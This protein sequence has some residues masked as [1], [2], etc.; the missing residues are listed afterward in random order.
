MI[1]LGYLELFLAILRRNLW[2]LFFLTLLGG[3]ALLC[4]LLFFRWQ[5]LIADEKLYQKARVELVAQSVDSVLRTQE[6]VLDV[7]GRELLNKDNMLSGSRQIPFLDSILAANPLLV[8]FG[9]ARPDGTLVRVSTNLDLSTLP[10]L[11]DDPET[12]ESFLQALSSKVM[13]VG[14]TYFVDAMGAWVIPIRKAIRSETGEV[15]AVMTAGMRLD[16]AGSVLSKTLHDSAADRVLLFR[17]ADGFVQF[18]SAEGVGPQQY[19]KIRVPVDE[20]EKNRTAFE[21]DLGLSVEEVMRRNDSVVVRTLR[22]GG[23]YLTAA[24]FNERYQLWTI[25]ETSFV[26]LHREF[27]ESLMQYL[28]VFLVVGVVFYRGFRI[29]DSA[30]KKRRQELSYLSKHDDL[31][32][33]LNRSGLLDCIADLL[34]DKKP[35]CLVVVN[36]DNFKGINDRFGLETGDEA[37]LEFSRRLAELVESR[38][39]LARLSGDEF[40]IVTSNS[41]LREVE[42][43]CLS[44]ANDLARAFEVGRLTLQVT[45]S[46]GVASFPEHGDSLSKVIRSAHLALYEAK[47]SR[48]DVC[49]YRTEMEMA[50][51]R[52]LSVEQR[53]RYGLASGA[54]YMAYQPQVDETKKTVGLEAL[55]R[56]SDEELGFVSPAEFVEVA[57]KSGLMLPLGRFVVETSIREYSLLRGSIGRSMDLAINISVIQFRQPDFVETVLG[58]LHVH[59]V[60]P[61]ELVLEITETL[62][63]SDFEKVLRTIERLREHGIRIS[64]DD[65]GTGY[66]S[67]S[68]LRKLPIDELKIDKSFVDTILEDEKAANMVRSIIAIARSHNMELV[69]EGVEEEAQARVLIEMGCRRF[70]GYFFSRP[71]AV[72]SLIGNRV[73]IQSDSDSMCDHSSH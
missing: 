68:L 69:A 53:L 50:Y 26:P 36:I 38:D 33:L 21:K 51:L 35:F 16:G 62:F 73:L 30:E 11:R 45:A 1:N 25:S 65:F 61:T 58:A 43:T 23:D 20:R 2:T 49:V 46:M 64:M 3:L 54:L 66:S 24:I 42:R 13:V 57:E 70:Q 52:R 14:R 17:E 15:L 8:G 12:R 19:S 55:V 7:I 56:W 39:D 47:Q 60:P 71:Q 4:A 72:D 63:M 67:L 32:G 40:A 22:P 31:T 5:G 28:L 18:M 41:S 34:P 44:L 27:S 48:N 10:N 37:L 6:L 9:L 29:I 59:D